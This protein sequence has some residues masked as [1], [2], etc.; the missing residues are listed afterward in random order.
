MG[1]DKAYLT[2]LVKHS[3]GVALSLEDDSNS[4]KTKR[5]LVIERR[6][7]LHLLQLNQIMQ[8]VVTDDIGPGTY[9]SSL[10]QVL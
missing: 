8:L 4:L 5:A 1:L 9:F 6:Q 2:I 7:T 10:S 3:E